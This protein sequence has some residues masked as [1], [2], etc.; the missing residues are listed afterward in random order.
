[1]SLF[2]KKP[3]KN[4]YSDARQDEFISLLFKNK[5]DG[6]FID[7]G[8]CH[9]INSNNTYHFAQKGWKGVCV[10]IGKEHLQSYETRPNTIFLNQ[11]ALKIEWELILK[12]VFSGEE[13]QYMSIDID[14]LSLKFLNIFPFHFRKPSVIT[15]EHDYYIYGDLYKSQ[16]REI[17]FS[18]GYKLLFGDVFVEQPGFKGKSCSF[19]DWWVS[20]DLK[21][22]ECIL[23]NSKS[24][25]A[26]SK[27]IKSLKKCP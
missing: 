8:A 23:E 21:I 2:S 22:N 14:T 20:S 12:S 17:L 7:I 15:I 25:V 5:T 11:D 13:I 18:L 3:K 24:E 26:P 27:I 6:N 10:E 1:M 16:Q 9:A 19:E 4:F